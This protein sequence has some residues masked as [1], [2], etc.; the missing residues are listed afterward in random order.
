MVSNSVIVKILD[1]LI[2]VLTFGLNHHKKKE[3]DD[4]DATR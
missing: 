3:D 4:V 1:V 2:T